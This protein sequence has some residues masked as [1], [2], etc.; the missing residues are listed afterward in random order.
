VTQ[1]MP[2]GLSAEQMRRLL[3]VVPVTPV[4][5]RDCAIIL[6]LVMTGRRRAEVLGMTASSI[7]VEDA[8]TTPTAARVGRRARVSYW[9]AKKTR[10][11]RR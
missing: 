4:G 1:V 10:A 8:S 2:R 7:S 3:E 6:T 5:L 11:G 9:T